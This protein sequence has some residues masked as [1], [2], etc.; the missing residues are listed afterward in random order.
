MSTLPSLREQTDR[1]VAVL[2]ALES[3]TRRTSQEW[4][5]QLP[6]MIDFVRGEVRR[7][8]VLLRSDS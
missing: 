1:L 8:V 4:L 3:A 6:D 2:P 7:V 5:P